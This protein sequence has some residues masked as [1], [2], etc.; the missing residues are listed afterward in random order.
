MQMKTNWTKVAGAAVAAISALTAGSTA[1]AQS[2]LVYDNADLPSVKSGQNYSP[3]EGTQF[4]NEIALNPADQYTLTSFSLEYNTSGTVGNALVTFYANTGALFNG[5]ANSQ[6][7]STVLGTLNTGALPATTSQGSTF[8]ITPS[9]TIVLPAQFTWTVSFTGGTA[10]TVGLDTYGPP[11]IGKAFN[12]IW[13]NTG[14]GWQLLTTV[15]GVT[16]ATFGAQINAITTAVTPEP[17]TMALG[18]M[19]VLDLGGMVASKRKNA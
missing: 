15:N 1:M 12:D 14:S 9:T 4:G 10:T 6:E 16:T 7:P 17:G 3:N 8:T 18:F 19:G 11:T 2:G 5:V 13:Q